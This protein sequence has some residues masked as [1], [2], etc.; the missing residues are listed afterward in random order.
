[1]SVKHGLLVTWLADR[2]LRGTHVARRGDAGSGQVHL[3]EYRR[4]VLELVQAIAEHNHDAVSKNFEL[5]AAKDAA[6]QAAVARCAWARGQVGWGRRRASLTRAAPTAVRAHQE[7][8]AKIAAVRG[9]IER[10]D[11]AIVSFAQDLGSIEQKLH[12]AVHD[13]NTLRNVD[14]IA[15]NRAQTARCPARAPHSRA[16]TRACAESF[17]VEELMVLAETLG[18]HSTAPYDFDEPSGMAKTYNPPVRPARFVAG[19]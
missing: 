11:K 9:E 8:E 12:E 10:L 19:L 13:P 14:G 16:P 18:M 7:A 4:L 6:L 15:T 2:P 17:N 3:D 5:I 1:M